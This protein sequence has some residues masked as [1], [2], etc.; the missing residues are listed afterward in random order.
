MSHL[1][2]HQLSRYIGDIY[3]CALSSDGLRELMELL[4]KVTASNSASIRIEDEKK[5]LVGGRSFNQQADLNDSYQQ[6]FYKHDPYRL[7]LLE[8]TGGC[9]Y[10]SYMVPGIQKAYQNS[11]YYNE[12]GRMLGVRYAMAAF[13]I[14]ADSNLI[15]IG[16]HR[17]ESMKSYISQNVIGMN[18]LLPHIKQALSMKRRIDEAVLNKSFLFSSDSS[19]DVAVFILNADNKILE[20]SNQAETMIEKGV[21]SPKDEYFRLGIKRYQ[22]RFIEIL[23]V[24]KQSTSVIMDFNESGSQF[25]RM[26]SGGVAYQIKVE[27]WQRI[28]SLGFMESGTIVT[29]KKEECVANPPKHIAQLYGLTHTESEV[30]SLL[31]QGISVKEISSQKQVKESTV[32]FHL[33][34]IY[35]KLGIRRNTQLVQ[36]VYQSL[37]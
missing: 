34:S 35:Q 37:I 27:P 22:A 20:R 4:T 17:P 2:M 24:A 19:R 23:E 13:F 18:L 14:D 8:Q 32:N 28:N 1:S 11:Y 21:V 15:R 25:A 3:S 10:A 6:K 26:E 29:L 12:C 16:F 9:F 31:C 7:W 30:A 33:K 5:Q 36:K